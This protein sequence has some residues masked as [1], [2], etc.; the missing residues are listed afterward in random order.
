M[1]NNPRPTPLQRAYVEAR[2]RQGL[3]PEQAY[4][5]AG[6]GTRKN[7][8]ARALELERAW[9]DAIAQETQE[10]L[11]TMAPG[12]LHILG[13]LAQNAQSESV[14]LR[15]VE[16][17][18]ALSGWHEKP[19]ATPKKTPAPPLPQE[20][21]KDLYA[22]LKEQIGQT[23]AFAI[24]QIMDPDNPDFQ[25]EPPDNPQETTTFSGAHQGQKNTPHNHGARAQKE[26]P[27][28]TQN[29]PQAPSYN[30]GAGAQNQG[31]QNTNPAPGQP[32]Q[33]SPA[34]PIPKEKR[35]PQP[36]PAHE[37]TALRKPSGQEDPIE[38]TN[39]DNP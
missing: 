18:L 25:R 3:C 10:N 23:R 39:P 34:K 5:A 14:R 11:S 7:V 6:F 17:L 9:R 32:S 27:E 19:S 36:N 30:H 21:T 35:H 2:V 28:N 13:Q 31:D 12:L 16:H 33:P 22:A 20:G 4:K 24:L 37:V 8:H 29:H 15:A 1:H 26:N 38:K